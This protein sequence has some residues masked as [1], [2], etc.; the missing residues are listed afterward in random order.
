MVCRRKQRQLSEVL[1]EYTNEE[2][3]DRL[4]L[5]DDPAEPSNP[6][7]HRFTGLIPV[8]ASAFTFRKCCL[9]PSVIENFPEPFVK[10][11]R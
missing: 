6:M 11:N 4:G 10:Q 2:L 8:R 9:R 1:Q 7:Q 5:D 3:F